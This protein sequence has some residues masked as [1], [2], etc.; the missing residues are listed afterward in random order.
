MAR[1]KTPVQC[2]YQKHEIR[3]A[4]AREEIPAQT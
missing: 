2:A 3:A 1:H 4:N